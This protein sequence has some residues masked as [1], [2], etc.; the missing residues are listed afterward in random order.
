MTLPTYKIEIAFNAGVSTPAASRTWTDVTAFVLLDSGIDI[1][2]GRGD[3]RSTADANTVRLTLNN[4]DGR[5]TAGRTGSPYYPNVRL[6]RPI[7]VTATAGGVSSVRYLGF[8]D[9]WPLDWPAQV[10]TFATAEITASSR[11]AWLNEGTELRSMLEE[12]CLVDNPVAYYTLGEAVGAASAA[13]SSGMASAAMTPGTFTSVGVPFAPNVTFGATGGPIPTGLTGV[14]ISSG[15]LFSLRPADTM[16]NLTIE[17][18]VRTTAA[19]TS[20]APGLASFH[21]A[22]LAMLPGGQVFATGS[23]GGSVSGVGPVINDGALHHIAMTIT[24]AGALTLFIDGAVVGAAAGA[25]IDLASTDATIGPGSAFSFTLFHVALYSTVLSGTRIKAHVD[26][27]ATGFVAEKPA[28]SA[29][30]TRFASY[31]DILPAELS[32]DGGQVPGLTY[33]DTTGSTAVDMMRKVEA[34]EEGI[35]F[36]RA[37]GLLAFHDRAHRY[38]AT[39]AFVLDVSQGQVGAAPQS[40]LDRGAIRNDVTATS[41]DGTVTAHV[42]NSS[43]VTNYGPARESLD[44]ATSNADEPFEHAS[45]LVNQY[46]EPQPRVPQLAVNL[47]NLPTTLTQS[48]L[49]AAVSTRFTVKSMA[50]QAATSSQDYYVEGYSESIGDARHSITFNI[51]QAQ[52][53][54]VWTVE[55]PVLGQYDAY[56]IAL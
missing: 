17:C 5:F 48:V 4:S 10:G 40:R 47:N 53:F 1:T 6:G 3:W 27:G 13:D 41:T 44:L 8:V 46:N 54:D 12:E 39:P 9:E 20:A 37:D 28:L 14:T 51:S 34:T 32:L 50:A 22:G 19:P 7:R 49:A 23:S 11:L 24:A 33:L 2:Y 35:L 43:S 31:A 52:P 36:D 21:G 45:W 38:S 30:L 29:R 25:T 42:V 15:K 18:W 16:T 56:P 26:A 55:D